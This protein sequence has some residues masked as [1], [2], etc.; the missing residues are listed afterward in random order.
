VNSL[1]VIDSRS[2]DHCAPPVLD[3]SRASIISNRGRRRPASE[4]RTSYMYLSASK[5]PSTTTTFCTRFVAN[6]PCP[7]TPTTPSLVDVYP[8]NTLFHPQQVQP[9]TTATMRCPVF[10]TEARSVDIKTIPLFYPRKTAPVTVLFP[11][12]HPQPPRDAF[13]C[14]PPVPPFPSPQPTHRGQ[15]IELKAHTQLAETLFF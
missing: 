15:N 9:Q 3:H 14:L 10:P 11:P 12:H 13:F 4:D 6:Q 1:I 7:R 2:L 8:R 5:S